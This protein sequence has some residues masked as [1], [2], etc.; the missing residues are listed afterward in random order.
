MNE[1]Q[2]LGAFAAISN[3]TRLRI[4]RMLVV[5]GADG[6]SAGFIAEALGAQP[7]RI[8]FH[9]SQLEQAGLVESRREGRSIIYSAI[10]PALS[11]LVAFLMR[12]CCE[13]HC[14]VCDKAIALFA[15]CTGRPTGPA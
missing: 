12:D 10:F 2:A 8:S 5:A 11:D 6:R 3:A 13:G 1:D 9:L 14:A 7:S 4:I 15:Q